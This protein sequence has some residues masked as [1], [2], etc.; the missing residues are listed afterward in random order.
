[1]FA[2]F[3]N[4]NPEENF[5]EISKGAIIEICDTCGDGRRQPTEECDDGWPLNGCL[6]DCSGSREGF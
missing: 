6:N 4:K 5:E 1:M 2:S 3:F